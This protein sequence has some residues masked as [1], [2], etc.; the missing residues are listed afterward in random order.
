MIV[1]NESK[2]KWWKKAIVA[3]IKVLLHDLPEGSEVNNAS[4]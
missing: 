2:R 3:W 4:I 1:H